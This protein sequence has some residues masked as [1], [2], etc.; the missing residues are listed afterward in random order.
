MEIKSI[1]VVGGG[2]M[3]RQIA[4]N[5]AIYG[6]EA[7]VYDLSEKVCADIQAWADDYMAGRVQ[8]GRMT[9]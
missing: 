5:A 3:G 2:R 7:S 8:K 1:C 9:Q 6:F 4:L